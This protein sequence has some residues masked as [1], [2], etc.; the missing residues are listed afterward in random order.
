MT[1]KV[2]LDRRGQHR[3]LLEG[4]DRVSVADTQ[5]ADREYGWL[6]DEAGEGTPEPRV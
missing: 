4:T 5:V 6:W 1:E 2:I 3:R